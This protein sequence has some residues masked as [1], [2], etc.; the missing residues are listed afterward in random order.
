MKIQFFN[1]KSSNQKESQ[2]TI[3]SIQKVM[4][5]EDSLQTIDYSDERQLYYNLPIKEGYDYVCLIPNGSGLSENYLELISEYEENEKTLYLPLTLLVHENIKGML[6]SC[7]WK[8]TTHEDEFGVLTPELALKQIDT[9]L[10]GALI[11]T[12][13][14]LDKDNYDESLK[15]YQ[16]FRFLNKLSHNNEYLILGVPKLLVTLNHDLSYKDIDEKEK[17][18]HYKKANEPW[19]KKADV[20]I[21]K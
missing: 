10:F 8:Y 6:N 20:V 11:P 5:K 19:T 9:T 14:I 17:I 3:E 21:L 15:Y 7:V 13:A 1:L 12:S 18:E 2:E 4:T 16:H